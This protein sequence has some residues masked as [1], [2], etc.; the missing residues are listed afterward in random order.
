MVN[1]T[2]NYE[3]QKNMGL[4]QT[5][6]NYTIFHSNSAIDDIPL[7]IPDL[8]IGNSRIKR[9]SSLKFLRVILDENISW[10]DHI[11]TTEKNC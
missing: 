11:E 7:K 9:K 8:K 3:L 5:K 10:K 4:V 6:S 1:G 2:V